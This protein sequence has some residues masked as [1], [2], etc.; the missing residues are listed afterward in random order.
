VVIVDGDW[1]VMLG[2]IGG[3]CVHECWWL[4][5]NGSDA[6]RVLMMLVFEGVM[7]VGLVKGVTVE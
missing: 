5:D 2:E 6:C 7:A 1:M 3:W 4:G